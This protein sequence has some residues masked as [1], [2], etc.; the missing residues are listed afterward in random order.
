MCDTLVE[1]NTDVVVVIGDARRAQEL[2]NILGNPPELPDI[3]FSIPVGNATT[4]VTGKINEG[5]KFCDRHLE[6]SIPDLD[7]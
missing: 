6:A 7:W 3:V 4:G 5:G 1:P 2:V